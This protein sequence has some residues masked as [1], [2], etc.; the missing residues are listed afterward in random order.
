M[1]IT[2]RK[3]FILCYRDVQRAAT[4]G[5]TGTRLYLLLLALRSFS[6]TDQQD[7]EGVNKVIKLLYDRAPTITLGLID[8]RV[9][10]KKQLGLVSKGVRT[11]KEISCVAA[12]L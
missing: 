12:E 9:R 7:I 10:L 4:T 5:T 11:F 3:I 1:D 6:H 8:A 2:T